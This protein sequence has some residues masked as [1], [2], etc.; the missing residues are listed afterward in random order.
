MT[1]TNTY[2]HLFSSIKIVHGYSQSILVDV[3]RRQYL[4]VGKSI[5]T[6]LEKID[7]LPL[8]VIQKSNL[9]AEPNSILNHLV[10]HEIGFFSDLDASFFPKIDEVFY[11]PHKITNIVWACLDFNTFDLEKIFKNNAEFFTN[12]ATFLFFK[13]I[14][15]REL[16]KLLK[17]IELQLSNLISYSIYIAE[18]DVSLRNLESIIEQYPR[19]SE[20]VI[21]NSDKQADLSKH[22][23]IVFS[24]QKLTNFKACGIV[25]K[26]D[27]NK[28]LLHFTES[29]DHNTCLNRKISVDVHGN[30][31]NCPSMVEQYG[32]IKDT[33][34]REALRHP[35]FKKYWSITKEQV[36]ICKDCEF[37]N[38]CTDCRA[39]LEDP[40][41]IYSK[42]LKCGYNP[43]T[44]EW[45]EWSTNPLK[46]KAID[47]Y[48]MR[49]LV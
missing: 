14:D 32:N 20:L 13:T 42:P 19:L 39:Y 45:G 17:L 31:K 43:Y 44:G 34:L 27:F 33:T 12:N 25:K 11:Y 49:T 21:F 1:K 4:A 28:S 40:E 36:S 6:A 15:K 30:I 2:F 18:I 9:L 3:H 48:G 37:R 16:L 8:E 29:L 5:A 26:T 7:G 46:Q 35:D 22:Q 24:K 38:I 47:Y 10:E 23:K 41:D